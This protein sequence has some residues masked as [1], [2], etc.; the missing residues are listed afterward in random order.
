[1]S[2]EKEQ[3]ERSRKDGF[4]GK[5]KRNHYY[6]KKNHHKKSDE[7]LNEQQ[8]ENTG[9]LKSM[10][11]GGYTSFVRE[12]RESKE[13]RKARDLKDTAREARESGEN[14]QSKGAGEPS[15]LRDFKDARDQHC[16]YEQQTKD[17]F[18]KFSRGNNR[19]GAQ[20]KD[21][22]GRKDYRKDGRNKDNTRHESRAKN[23]YDYEPKKN[24]G[25]IPDTDKQ[26]I[27]QFV[28]GTYDAETKNYIFSFDTG[29]YRIVEKIG[30]GEE[31]TET[32]LLNSRDKYASYQSWNEIKR[33]KD[34]RGKNEK[35]G[36]ENGKEHIS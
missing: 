20:K 8:G 26:A 33:P 31:A 12:S 36:K 24:S 1:M 25:Y 4:D 21:T 6:H 5:K 16:D 18:E 3:S 28:L 15:K 23:H 17:T 9:E 14:K 30:S 27:R 11:N 19:R 7:R 22:F 34:R 13:A 10:A 29:T 32:E 2:N 35:E